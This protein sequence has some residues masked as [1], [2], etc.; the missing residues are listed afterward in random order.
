[1]RFDRTFAE[2]I[3]EER[4][5]EPTLRTSCSR[6][7]PRPNHEV[8]SRAKPDLRFVDPAAADITFDENL[9]VRGEVFEGAF[10]PITRDPQHYDNRLNKSC[11]KTAVSKV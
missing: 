1:M 7:W 8:L 11:V 2:A 4:R 10:D 6:S 5:V 3:S 9:T